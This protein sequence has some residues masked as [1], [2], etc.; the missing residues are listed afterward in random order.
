MRAAIWLLVAIAALSYGIYAFATVDRRSDEAQLTALVNDAAAAVQKQDLNG[1]ISCVSKDYKDDSGLNYDRLRLLTAQA[2]RSEENYT[3]N[4]DIKNLQ[5][6]GD[7]ATIKLRAKVR[8]SD[9]SRIV[10][11]R[12]LTVYLTKENA[13]H[14][15]IIPV[16]TWRVTRIEKL[17]FEDAM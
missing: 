5:I 1:T 6:D 7:T 9:P 16:K 8:G 14:A 12:D 4:T 13:R 2:L 3:A 11:E 17:G 15:L 10:Y